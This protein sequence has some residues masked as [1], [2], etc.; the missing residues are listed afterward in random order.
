[1]E[2]SHRSPPTRAEF[3]L[4][5]QDAWRPLRWLRLP[6]A[7]RL[8]TSSGQAAGVA[9]RVRW[10]TLE[11]RAGL[12]FP[13]SR[14]GLI[15]RASWSRYAHLLQ[16]RYLDFGNPAALGEQLF[17]WQ[18]LNGDGQAQPQEIGPRLQVFGGPYSAVDRGLMRPFTDEVSVGVEQGFAAHFSFSVRFFRRDD[19]RQIGLLNVGVPP[20]DYQ[21]LQV[22]DPGNDGIPGTSDDQTLTLYNRNGS[23]LGRDFFLLTNSPGDRAS[24]KGFEIRLTK[25]LVR[26]WE[27]SAS[28]TATRTL[29]PTSPGNSV[30]ENDTGFLGSLYTDPNTLR[31]DTG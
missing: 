1:M 22:L 17:L 18:D 13:L 15:L 8:E 30:F 7:L 2:Y 5:A 11:P 29:A 12:V 9:N 28:F 21:P 23:A 6:V 10:T 3:R 26:R 31:F 27:F 19:H 20:A 24:F 25:P 4:V 14:R 16:G